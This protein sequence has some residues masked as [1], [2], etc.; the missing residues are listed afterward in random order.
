MGEIIFPREEHTN[1]LSNTKQS[2][3][4]AYTQVALDKYI[5]FGIHIYIVIVGIHTPHTHTHTHRFVVPAKI[6][7]KRRFHEFEGE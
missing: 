2:A 7:R 4:K 5:I 1:C 3:L 6:I